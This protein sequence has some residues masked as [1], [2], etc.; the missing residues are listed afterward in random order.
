[1]QTDAAVVASVFVHIARGRFRVEV[2]AGE[3]GESGWE[4][5]RG[6]S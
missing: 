4:I 5:E 1:M 3:S 6:S 2:V